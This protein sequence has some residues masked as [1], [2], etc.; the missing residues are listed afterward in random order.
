MKTIGVQA[1]AAIKSECVG[2]T[3]PRILKRL[4]GEKAMVNAELSAMPPD[5]LFGAKA[6]RLFNREQELHTTLTV[7]KDMGVPLAQIAEPAN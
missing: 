6:A 7:L 2:L 3:L 4:E 1:K 5:E